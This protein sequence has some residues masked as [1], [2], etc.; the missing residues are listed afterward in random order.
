MSTNLFIESPDFDLIRKQS[1]YAV[2]DAVRLLWSTLNEEIRLRRLTVRQA[3]EKISGKVKVD[4]TTSNQNNYDT[5]ES[6]TVYF[7]GGSACDVTGVRNGVEGRVVIFTVLGT[8]TFTF[9]N[10]SASSDTTNKILMSAGA[11]KAVAT[12][13]SIVLQYLNARWRELTPA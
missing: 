6:Q 5:E 8:G 13:K 7:T 12:N 11:D 4:S 3:T 1:G 2:E 10:N 9:K